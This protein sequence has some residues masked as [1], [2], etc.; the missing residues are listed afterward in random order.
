MVLPVYLSPGQPHGEG[1][2][3]GPQCT[4]VTLALRG[5]LPVSLQGGCV[6][7]DSGVHQG[8][9]GEVSG[10]EQRR[11]GS[12]HA[13]VV[14]PQNAQRVLEAVQLHLCDDATNEEEQCNSSLQD[15]TIVA[16]KTLQ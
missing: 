8:E 14:V 5:C 10:R 7:G 11:P 2:L 13:Q 12:A 6:P 3:A 1:V 16:Y 15:I 4:V 9:T